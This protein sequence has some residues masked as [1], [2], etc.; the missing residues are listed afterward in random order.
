MQDRRPCKCQGRH[1]PP[2]ACTYLGSL[3]FCKFLAA[4]LLIRSTYAESTPAGHHMRRWSLHLS[5][6]LNPD[7]VGHK[8]TCL[9]TFCC[10]LLAGIL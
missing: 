7:V 8:Y 3:L 5:V 2:L 1:F 9:V 10:L 4:T 6:P